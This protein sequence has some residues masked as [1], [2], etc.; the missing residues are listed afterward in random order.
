MRRRMNMKLMMKLS[1]GK[2]EDHSD[3]RASD[4]ARRRWMNKRDA[5]DKK[6]NS[7]R[8][9][10]VSGSP[11]RRF[12]DIKASVAG[13]RPIYICRQFPAI[14]RRCGYSLFAGHQKPKQVRKCE[15]E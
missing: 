11:V 12:A 6:K 10:P 2:K 1:A 5:F 4:E 8:C 9:S 14:I 15:E 13:S 3:E 7:S